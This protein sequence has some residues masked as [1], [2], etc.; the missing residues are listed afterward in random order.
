MDI[1][2]RC[3]IACT[4]AYKLGINNLVE[5][6]N[7]STTVLQTAETTSNNLCKKISK[8]HRDRVIKRRHCWSPFPVISIKTM[9]D[10]PATFLNQN[11]RNRVQHTKKSDTIQANACIWQLQC[12]LTLFSY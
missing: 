11:I 1:T 4:G 8:V 3:K 10:F 7:T 12:L 2:Y 6:I 5:A 9:D